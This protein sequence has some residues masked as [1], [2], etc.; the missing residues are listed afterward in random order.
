VAQEILYNT[1]TRCFTSYN[2]R[3]VFVWNP[4]NSETLFKYSFC[5][6]IELKSISC[7]CYSQKYHLYF[8]FTHSCK[9]VVL[10]EYLN[11]IT[12]I[13]TQMR[14]VM[15]CYFVDKTT[16]LVTAGVE[17]CHLI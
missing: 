3:E 2:D 17:E 8:A 15:Q 6:N 4:L 11:L 5:D 14:R 7:L 1:N 13:K 16:Q 10:N 12:V 9:I